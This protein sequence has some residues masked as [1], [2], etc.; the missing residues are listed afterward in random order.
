MKAVILLRTNAGHE[1]EA[2]DR[3]RNAIVSEVTVTERLHVYGRVDG[4]VI[5]EANNPAAFNGLAEALR[6]GGTFHT[7]TLISIGE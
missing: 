1:H 7:E 6:Q 4:L 5:C 3:L 2:Y